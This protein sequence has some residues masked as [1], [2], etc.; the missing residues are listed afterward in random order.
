MYLVY[1]VVGAIVT[2]GLIFVLEGLLHYKFRLQDE[3]GQYLPWV[4]LLWPLGVPFLIF[5][6]L[7]LA[8]IIFPILEPLIELW[9]N[10]PVVR[11]FEQRR[12][13][14]MSGPEKAKK[15][16]NFRKSRLIVYLREKDGR[17]SSFEAVLIS[18][19]LKIG[20]TVEH[21]EEDKGRAIAVGD[22]GSLQ[23][24]TLALVGTAWE[25]ARDEYCGEDVGYC[26]VERTFCDYRL[27]QNDKGVLRIVAAGNDQ[28][29][30]NN[31]GGLGDLIVGRLKSSLPMESV[32]KASASV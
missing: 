1:Y 4:T 26:R 19:L 11:E 6:E 5:S 22:Q 2:A 18:A 14:E 24:G 30:S 32:G 7:I 27:I 15:L 20:V 8:R 23:H 29:T 25:S 13:E 28:D 21:I 17:K 16:E 31:K 12:L 3:P 10:S 9:K